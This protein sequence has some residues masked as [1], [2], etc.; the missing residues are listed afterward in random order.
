MGHRNL[1]VYSSRTT[2]ETG[3]KLVASNFL[4]TNLYLE[5]VEANF[6]ATFQPQTTRALFESQ[7]PNNQIVFRNLT[8]R[9][10][11]LAKLLYF[12][13]SDFDVDNLDFKKFIFNVLFY[14]DAFNGAYSYFKYVQI[15]NSKII[16]CTGFAVDDDF[17]ELNPLIRLVNRTI[18]FPFFNQKVT[19][20]TIQ[21][22]NVRDIVIYDSN[23]F[24]EEYLNLLN[25]YVKNVTNPD[26]GW[27]V[28]GGWVVEQYIVRNLTFIGKG[29]F[30]QVFFPKRMPRLILFEDIMFQNI[31][32]RSFISFRTSERTQSDFVFRCNRMKFIYDED[33]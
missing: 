6:F 18:K 31:N 20:Q 25:I 22:E 29:E 23:Q 3:G 16:D 14:S 7:H 26:T 30:E 10:T 9:D 11:W 12:S 24:Y 28:F 33:L 1:I 5:K 8:I 19:L 21:I 27:N 4:I 17:N 2:F 13:N 15:T 32:S